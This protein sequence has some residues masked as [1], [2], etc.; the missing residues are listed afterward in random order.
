ML[1]RKFKKV[2]ALSTVAALG[3][4]QGTHAIDVMVSGFIRQEMAYKLSNDEKPC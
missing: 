3:F 1:T 2:A 4:S